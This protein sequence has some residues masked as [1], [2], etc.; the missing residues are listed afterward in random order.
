MRIFYYTFGCKVNQYETENI[1]ELFLKEGHCDA[2]DLLS[3]DVCIINSC[4]V[5][6]QS[7]SKCRQLVHRIRNSNPECVIVL[8]GCLPQAFKDSA[9]KME[10]CDIISGTGRKRDIPE[11]VREFLRTGE[12]IVSVEDRK[13]GEPF[14]PMKNTG[15]DDKTR[16]YI[17]IQDGC[18]QY[19]SYCIIPYAR[20]HICSKSLAD[21]R[22]ETLELVGSGHREIILTGI[23]LCC[24]GRDLS[25]GTRLIDAVEA[26]CSTEGDFRVRLGS[27]EPE[28]ISDDDIARMSE[29]DRL[30]PHFHL[31]LQSGCDATLKR[32]RRHYSSGEFM[33]LCQKLRKYFPGCAITTDIMVGFPGETEEEFNESLE[34]VKKTGFSDAHIF[35]YS[36]R[37]G[38]AA[39]KM[40]GQTDKKTKQE[41]ARLITEACR[42][43][44]AEY[45]KGCIGMTLE[46]LFEKETSCDWHNGHAPNYINV[47]VR[48]KS[49]S[50]SLRREL[51]QVR[52]TS[53]DGSFC[54]GELI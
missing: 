39:D 50:D 36:R 31:S 21:I 6:A 1:R 48:R 14:E 17:K 34:F 40:D 20:G 18:D 44:R 10:E 52:I 28:M 32:M 49:P 29:L 35:P 5:T 3:A 37:K 13:P 38:T 54:Y 51:R 26:A 16:A 42:I 25:N 45:L 27:I 9:E 53:S 43:S 2:E 12:R 47:R 23:N 19:C 33:L 15:S 7:D 8:A 24:Y 41:R 46:V 30:C 11:L 22:T 4:T